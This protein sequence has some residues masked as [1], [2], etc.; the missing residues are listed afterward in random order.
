MYN[1]GIANFGFDLNL[2]SYKSFFCENKKQEKRF[3]DQY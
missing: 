2:N 3:T 1:I